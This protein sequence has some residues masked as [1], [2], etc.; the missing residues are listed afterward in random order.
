MASP[1]KNS[2]DEKSNISKN[3][4]EEKMSEFNTCPYKLQYSFGFNPDVPLV[5]LTTENRTLIAY[6]C[7]HVP[8]ICDYN[9]NKMLPLQGHKNNIKTLSTSNNGKWLLTAD[10]EHDC[11]VIVWD[12]EITIPIR[13]LFEPHGAHGLTAARISPNAKYIVTVGNEKLQQVYFWLWTYGRDKPDATVELS[14]V[15]SD[16]VKEI[17]FDNDFPKRFALTTDHHVLF[18][19]WNKNALSYNRPEIIGKYR[20]F[21]ILNSSTFISKSSNVLTATNTGFVLVWAYTP[22]VKHAVQDKNLKMKYIKSVKLQTCNIT[23]ILDYEG[24]AVTGNSNGRIT[25]YDAQLKLLYWCQNRELDSIRSITFDLYSELFGCPYA[26]SDTETES[27][28]E[29]STSEL[30]SAMEDESTKNVAYREESFTLN[31]VTSEKKSYLTVNLE[32]IPKKYYDE[33]N[34]TYV[35][36]DATIKHSKFI[37]KNCIVS[38][39]KGTLALLDI[40]NLKCQLISKCLAAPVTSLDAH[41]ENTYLIT[42]NKEGILNLYDYRKRSLIVS[43]QVPD[44]PDF[45]TILDNQM[46][47]NK[48]IYVTCPQTHEIL[49]AITALKFTPT[50]DL[51][52]C[53]MEDGTFWVLHP[54]TLELLDDLPYKHSSQSIRIIAFTKCATYMA[55][56]DDALSIVVFRKNDSKS[57]DEA[58]IWNLIG[59]CHSHCLPI[60]QVLFGPSIAGDE[61][62]RLFSLGEDG[63]IIEYD[64][65]T[66]GPYPDPGLK[67]LQ[68]DRIETIATP[69]HMEWY[70]Q[71]GVETLFVISNSEHKYRL[72]NDITRM[73]R[74]TFLSPTFETPVKRFKIL[75]EN[76]N[77]IYMVFTTDK[78]LG[79]QILPLDGNPYTSLGLT[80]HP[81]KITG[82]AVNCND[83]TVFTMGYKDPC[84]LIWKIKFRSVNIMKHL[85]GEGLSPFYSLIKGRENGWLVNE[86]RDLFYYAQIL[87]QGENTMKP[88]K[89]SDKVSIKQIPN[90]MRTVGYFPSNK[91]LENIICEVSYRNYAE[92]GQLLEDITYEDFVKL[93]INH[94]P[95]FGYSIRQVRKA[96]ATFC[97]R[98]SKNDEDLVLTRDQFMDILFGRYPG[99]TLQDD[100]LFGEPLTLQEA[101]TYLQL[102][103]PQED[104]NVGLCVDPKRQ[105]SK[106]INFDFLPPRISYKDFVTVI[107]GV[108]VLEKMKADNKVM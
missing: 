7:S 46:E 53:G 86:M 77:H 76:N 108:E 39:A 28:T 89:I 16:R 12:T 103:I 67:I 6:A 10:F 55:Y 31:A 26:T 88:R 82:F 51:L 25:F 17:C 5:N 48:I 73:I 58:N 75:K 41:P 52:I 30:D 50:S 90:L 63:D 81:L 68:I 91:E 70:P 23:V 37:V 29:K 100:K 66:S 87:Q 33:K 104:I 18:F 102:L 92:T 98:E 54:I 45:S 49:T 84:V 47:T 42:G 80:G 57:P 59:K 65:E 74:G 96:F 34:S 71:F 3:I 15:Q 107:L 83:D 35:A 93:Y 106:S 36:V 94:R 72:L 8:M 32:P 69:L 56:S 78:E 61:I 24:M 20:R 19:T 21:G 101:H 13:T 14:D 60:R 99:K 97:E 40:P 95:V 2:D 79:L 9:S 105:E 62:P 11:A 27:S 44:L 38:T 4:A 1:S 43:R 22:D 64:L 85:G